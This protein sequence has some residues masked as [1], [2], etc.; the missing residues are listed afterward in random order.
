MS[1]KRPVQ[2]GRYWILYTIK[3][4]IFDYNIKN[5]IKTN[6]KIKTCGN[7]EDIEYYIL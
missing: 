2:F 1:I 7:L 4:I 3:T 5:N 6:I